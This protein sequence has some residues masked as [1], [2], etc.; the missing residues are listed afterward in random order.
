VV[1]GN[2]EAVQIG[3]QFNGVSPLYQ[4]YFA[5]EDWVAALG[6]SLG[7]CLS[8]EADIVVSYDSEARIGRILVSTTPDE[9]RCLPSVTG[10]TLDL[11]ALEP[12]GRALAAYR[13]T[14][15]AERDIRIASFR[16]GVR[17][18][19]GTDLCEVYIGGQFP[20]DGT[21]FSPCVTLLGHETC[22]GD[23]HTPVTELPLT[24]EVG[25]TLRRCVRR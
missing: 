19:R 24:G 15:A 22:L 4:G 1:G 12:I 25:R 2:G 23:R 7:D 11:T 10:D 8:G 14:I 20:P 13:D 16:S 6:A 5:T 18:L 17:L 3:L 9:L 21:T